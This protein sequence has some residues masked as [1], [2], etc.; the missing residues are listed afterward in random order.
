MLRKRGQV[1][2]KNNLLKLAKAAGGFDTP[3]G[4][5]ETLQLAGFVTTTAAVDELLASADDIKAAR[6]NRAHNVILRRLGHIPKAM[7]SAQVAAQEP[8]RL[9]EGKPM[10]RLNAVRVKSV[11]AMAHSLLRHGAAGGHTMR[12]A[13]ALDASVVNYVVTMDQNRDTYAGA[14]KGWTANEDHHC[15]TVPQDW[16][17]R[18]ERKGLASLG[19]MMT[20]DAHPLM[21]DGDVQV[22]AATWARQGRGFEVQVDRGYIAMLGREHF[23]AETAQAAIKGVRRKVKSASA[24]TRAV[25][26]SPYALTVEAFVSRYAKRDGMVSVRDAQDSGSCD[27]GIRSW[28]A[29]VGLEYD[30]GEAPLGLVLDGFRLRPQDE[31][32][33]AVV[34][35]LRRQRAARRGLVG[36]L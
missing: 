21:P 23:H 35:A 14:Y 30:A 11:K 33:R 36:E 7:G 12:V 25:A 5:R 3:K 18:V 1:P 28:C 10:A 15:I 19:G 16:R 32:R 34:Y 6:R 20:L 24:P 27:F 17:L 2:T 8:V 9:P 31:V 4:A 29:F 13:F 26:V 22:Y